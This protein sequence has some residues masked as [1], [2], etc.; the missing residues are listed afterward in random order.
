[1]YSNEKADR[2]NLREFL[3]EKHTP[4]D[5]TAYSDD[6]PFWLQQP[7]YGEIPGD[8]YYELLEDRFL[9]MP[10]EIIKE[11]HAYYNTLV[12]LPGKADQLVYVH[13]D[14]LEDVYSI[15]MHP[16]FKNYFTVKEANRAIW[17]LDQ[18]PP[19]FDLM[20]DLGV[21][22][23]ANILDRDPW[24]VLIPNFDSGVLDFTLEISALFIRTPG[25]WW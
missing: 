20:C 21:S 2:V 4:T 13:P 22:E 17:G 11:H 10:E 16:E 25:K 5:K 15:P 14:S 9:Y 18:E 8:I 19:Y 12:L 3:R 24:F 6:V 1:M 23:E 7:S